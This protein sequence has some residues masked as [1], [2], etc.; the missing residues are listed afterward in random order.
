MQDKETVVTQYAD[1]TNL[2][3]RLLIHQKYSTNKQDFHHWIFDQMGLKSGDRM[4]EF[5]CGP[6]TFW[7]KNANRLPAH[8][9]VTLSDLSQGMVMEAKKNV[10][11]FLEGTYKVIDI[12]NPDFE[13]E[14]ADIII[15]N[16]MLYHVPNLHKA[17]NEV[18]RILK[19][20]SVFFAATN[21]LRHMIELID[22][23]TEYDSS[24]SFYSNG[25][26]KSFSLEEGGKELERHFNNV[27]LQRFDSHLVVT[28]IEHLID[29]YESMDLGL[30]LN[31]QDKRSDFRSFLETKSQDGTF[32]ITK[33]SGLFIAEK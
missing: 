1:S 4:I 16:H 21:G 17:L 28:N 5:G 30:N 25:F 29:Y 32:K 26:M 27:H 3:K 12:Q 19:P 9:E 22:W 15:C 11:G 10:E 7:V 8:L 20:N 33:D 2:K 31:H 13:S 6:G 23:L 14:I 18:H 24:I